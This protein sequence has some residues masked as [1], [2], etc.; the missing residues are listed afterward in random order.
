[1]FLFFFTS[2][3]LPAVNIEFLTYRWIILYFLPHGLAFVFK[4]IYCPCK[5]VLTGGKVWPEVE[6]EIFTG[7][8]K[9]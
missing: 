7:Q 6:E 8:S 1:M 9:P 2:Q 4:D 3:L 5:E